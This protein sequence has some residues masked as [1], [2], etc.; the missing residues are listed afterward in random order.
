MAENYGSK[1]YDIDALERHSQKALSEE[2]VSQSVDV[3]VIS[4][5]SDEDVEVTGNIHMTPTCSKFNV[6]E[7]PDCIPCEDPERDM[8]RSKKWKV[9]IP[10]GDYETN[11]NPKQV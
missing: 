6:N 10:S 7:D 5:E 9:A 11:N 2:N 1:K 4:S 8:H 3:M